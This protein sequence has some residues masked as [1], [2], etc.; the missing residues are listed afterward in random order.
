MS[1]VEVSIEISMFTQKGQRHRKKYY[2]GQPHYAIAR[3]FMSR[4]GIAKLVYGT[5]NLGMII[6]M[7]KPLQPQFMLTHDILNSELIFQMRNHPWGQENWVAS[8]YEDQD[9]KAMPIVSVN[10]TSQQ[11]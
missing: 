6:T 4:P 11:Q 1:Y 8:L 9:P 2:S 5:T 10:R 7:Y 3:W